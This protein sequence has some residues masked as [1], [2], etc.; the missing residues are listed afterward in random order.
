MRRLAPPAPA[1][2]QFL[3]VNKVEA[4]W[5]CMAHL[6]AYAMSTT[7]SPYDTALQIRSDVFT[8]FIFWQVMSQIHVVITMEYLDGLHVKYQYWS[9]LSSKYHN[10]TFNTNEFEYNADWL[11]DFNLK[12]GNWAVEVLTAGIMF[13]SWLP[14]AMVTMV[15]TIDQPL[16]FHHA[17]RSLQWCIAHVWWWP[18]YPTIFC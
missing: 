7:I 9:Y 8:L 3:G 6:T 13:A 4:S 15:T 17:P 11:C 1:S 5:G 18:T 12:G 2:I 16:S 14:T 10:T